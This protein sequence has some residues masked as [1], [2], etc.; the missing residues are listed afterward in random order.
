MR[1]RM[2]VKCPTGAPD[3]L[4]PEECAKEGEAL[5]LVRLSLGAEEAEVLPRAPLKTDYI[6]IYICIVC[7]ISLYQLLIQ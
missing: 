7:I 3:V 6:Y 2:R 4:N 5:V 1:M